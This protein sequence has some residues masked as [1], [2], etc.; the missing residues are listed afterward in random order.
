MVTTRN[1]RVVKKSYQNSQVLPSTHPLLF[2]VGEEMEITRYYQTK[3]MVLTV[4]KLRI[5]K[6]ITR[7]NKRIGAVIEGNKRRHSS[8]KGIIYGKIGNRKGLD[9][10]ETLQPYPNPQ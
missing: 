10:L 7:P 3:K 8:I 4:K 1:R 9:R 2:K 5:V 6:Q